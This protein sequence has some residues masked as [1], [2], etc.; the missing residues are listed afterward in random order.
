MFHHI[1]N[2][3]LTTDLHQLAAG[4]DHLSALRKRTQNQEQSRRIIVHRNSSLRPRDLAQYVLNLSAPFPPAS[5]FQIIFQITVAAH[6]LQHAGRRFLSK[7]R[8]AEVRMQDRP[9][10]VQHLFQSGGLHLEQPRSDPVCQHILT[11]R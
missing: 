4:D 1:R 11:L 8:S 5:V 9:G 10:S 2:P 3:E 6:R 7:G